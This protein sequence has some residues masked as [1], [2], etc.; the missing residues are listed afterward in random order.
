MNA[1]YLQRCVDEER[2]AKIAAG[3]TMYATPPPPP[4]P[5]THRSPTTAHHPPIASPP[6]PIPRFASKYSLCSPTTRVLITATA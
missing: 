2:R 6:F 4:P 5:H 1:A 3:F